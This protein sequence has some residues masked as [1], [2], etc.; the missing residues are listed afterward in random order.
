MKIAYILPSLINKGPIVV[1]N[2][3]TSEL[4]KQNIEIDIF[5][6]DDSK[7][8]MKFDSPTH[9]IDFNVPIDFNGYD[10]IHSHMYRPDK[11]VCKWYKSIDHSKT[12]LVST[13]HQDI[14]GNIKYSHNI[15]SAIVLDF[16]WKKYL[17]KFDSIANIS[18]RLLK[19][20]KN[21]L[22]QSTVVYNGVKVDYKPQNADQNIVN[23]ILELKNKNL[24]IIG[25]Y[26]ALSRCKGVDQVFKLLEAR[27][28]L[29]FVLISGEGAERDKLSNF[30]KAKGFID[31]VLFLP[32]LKQPYN[33][34]ENFDVYVMPSRSEGFGLAMAEAALTK[35][36]VVCSD[37]EVFREIFDDG[38]A[39][40]FELENIES[41]N[42]AVDRAIL[43]KETLTEK[44]YVKVKSEFTYSIMANNYLS[45][46]KSLLKI[47]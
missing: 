15:I 22:P 4:V 2:S 12:K 23:K 3:I 27:V 41:L 11:Y 38:E 21:V 28:D 43:E 30:A 18:N 47:Q 45:L 46:Y 16:V 7:E 6:F 31:R 17:K 34:L 5:Y 40:F 44:A 26:A 33:Y 8:Q 19:I 32:Y 24:K 9:K 1:V 25:C 13:I 10:I 14:I 35:T 37:I 29:G 36:P 39:A 20:Y 42:K